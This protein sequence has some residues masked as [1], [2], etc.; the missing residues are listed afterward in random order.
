MQIYFCRMDANL[1]VGRW[2]CWIIVESVIICTHF[3]ETGNNALRMNQRYECLMAFPGAN[4]PQNCPTTNAALVRNKCIRNS[5]IY[6]KTGRIRKSFQHGR[7]YWCYSRNGTFSYISCRGS[8]HWM[9]VSRSCWSRS[10]KSVRIHC[11][12]CRT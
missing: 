7:D 12:A 4:T 5:K 2:A 1:A 8:L 9:E 11:A 10:W 3:E 6:Y